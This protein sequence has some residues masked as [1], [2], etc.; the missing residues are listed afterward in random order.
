M[1]NVYRIELPKTT[2]GFYSNNFLA[3][4]ECDTTRNMWYDFKNAQKKV[5][6]E[7]SPTPSEDFKNTHGYSHVSGEHS[8]KQWDEVI[9]FTDYYDSYD[10]K[11]ACYTKESL[12]KWLGYNFKSIEILNKLGFQ[13]VEYFVEDIHC[14]FLKNQILYKSSKARKVK[15]HHLLKDL[16]GVTQ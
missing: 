1:A 7:Y 9:K 16:Q 3:Q 14:Y 13:L 2:E 10:T 6:H 8:D 4:D 11:Y 5:Q 12:M 15:T